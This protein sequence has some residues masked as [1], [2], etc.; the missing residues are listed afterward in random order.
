MGG[1]EGIGLETEDFKRP[2]MTSFMFLKT[3]KLSSSGENE[4]REMFKE[5]FLWSR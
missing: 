2:S 4:D 1:Q 3:K 5:V